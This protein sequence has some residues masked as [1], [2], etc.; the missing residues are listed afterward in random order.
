LEQKHLDKGKFKPQTH[1]VWP[2]DQVADA[3]M[4]TQKKKN[5]GKVILV[6]EALQEESK[7]IKE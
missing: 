5:V 4:Q 7:N 6:P 1:S 2:F 3:M